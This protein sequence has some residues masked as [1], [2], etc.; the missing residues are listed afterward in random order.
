MPM[1]APDILTEARG[2]P[3]ALS[4]T[5]VTLGLALWGCGWSFHRFWIVLATTLLAGTLVLASGP[6]AGA[7]PL[8]AAVLLAVGAGAL[9]LHLSRVIAFACGGLALAAAVHAALPSW[10]QPLPCFVAGGLIALLLFRPCIMVL[11]SLGGTLL[12]GYSALLL[13][14]RLGKLDAVAWSGRHAGWLNW[15]CVG[16]MLAG[17]LLQHTVERR[18]G[19][20]DQQRKEAEAQILAKAR[21]KEKEQKEKDKDKGKTKGKPWWGWEALQALRKAG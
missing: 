12:M 4:G 11:T 3:V 13:A 9:A 18:R 21:E 5:G 6:V 15:A 17:W 1:L 19:E 7:Q 14:D 10:E 2:L 20:R 16:V 8:V